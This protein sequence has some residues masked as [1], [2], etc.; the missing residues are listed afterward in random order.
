MF[1]GNQMILSTRFGRAIN[2]I[3]TTTPNNQQA[4]IM[5]DNIYSPAASPIVGN[6]ANHP[7]HPNT[8]PNVVIGPP[9]APQVVVDDPVMA[10]RAPWARREEAYAKLFANIA[11]LPIQERPAMVLQQLQR[12]LHEEAPARV[13]MAPALPRR[14]LNIHD[15]EALADDDEVM[16]HPVREFGIHLGARIPEDAPP[17]IP[18]LG[19]LRTSRRFRLPPKMRLFDGP[20]DEPRIGQDDDDEP[21][22][23][24]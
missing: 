8:P 16:P 6:M 15:E 19:N 14:V 24:N 11:A 3:Q 12:M 10:F 18:F 23:A 5:T 22:G 1:I 17:S 7:N 21:T 13:E 9:P 20:L 4:I 2:F